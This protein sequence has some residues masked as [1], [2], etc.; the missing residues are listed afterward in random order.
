M[1]MKKV[2][3]CLTECPF[4]LDHYSLML[5]LVG[6]DMTAGVGSRENVPGLG[7]LYVPGLGCLY[8]PALEA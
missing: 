1:T 5:G 4:L 7:C 6:V 2:H 3:W 8:V